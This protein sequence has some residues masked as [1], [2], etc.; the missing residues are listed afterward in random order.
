MPVS[1][2]PKFFSNGLDLKWMQLK[3]EAQRAHGGPWKPFNPEVMKL[4]ARLMTFSIPSICAVNGH[5]FGAGMMIALCHDARFMRED[6]GVMCANEVELGFGPCGGVAPS[7]AASQPPVPAGSLPSLLS[8]SPSP[9]GPSPWA[10][11]YM[12]RPSVAPERN[13]AIPEP[14]LALFRHK[15]P[16]HAFYDTVMLAKRWKGPA[17]LAAGFVHRVCPRESLLEEAIAEAE[18][19]ARRL[20][21][22]RKAFRWQKEHIY[23]EHAAIQGVHGPAY[24]LRH[25]EQFAFGPG[26]PPTAPSAKL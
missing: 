9:R 21:R 5:C 17:A 6:R 19:M 20:T 22:N 4:F 25:P 8:P 15:L 11:V 1:A 3:G 10:R 24:M 7:P 23:G 2:D 18:K 16:M 26:S 12:P 13:T 14:E